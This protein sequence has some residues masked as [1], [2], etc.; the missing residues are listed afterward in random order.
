MNFLPQ[1]KFGEFYKVDRSGSAKLRREREELG[2]ES[3]GKSWVEGGTWKSIL[4]AKHSWDG[5][6]LFSYGDS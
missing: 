2:W 1:R 4:F 3:C 5:V 6:R